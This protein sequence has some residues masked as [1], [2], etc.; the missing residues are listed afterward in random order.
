MFREDD[1][2]AFVQRVTDIAR[3]DRKLSSM[4]CE[5]RKLVEEKFSWQAT[6]GKYDEILERFEC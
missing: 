6:L 4:S 5:G 2:D 1:W 3:D